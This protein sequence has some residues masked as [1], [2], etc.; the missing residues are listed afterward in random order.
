MFLHAIMHI[1]VQI[2]LLSVKKRQT[3]YE[4]QEEKQDH[5]L[6]INNNSI[7][8]TPCILMLLIWNK[9]NIIT[10]AQFHK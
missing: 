6:N 5:D 10:A 3:F 9:K 2:S 7:Q 1:S 4:N 8:F